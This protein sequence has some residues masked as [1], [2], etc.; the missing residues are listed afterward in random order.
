M[1]QVTEINV[2]PIK[3]CGRIAK[4]TAAVGP[5]GLDGDRRYMLVDENGRFVTQRQH[6]RM[7]LIRVTELEADGYRIEAPGRP[8]LALPRS[9]DSGEEV[10]VTLWRSRVEA[11]LVDDESS[12][13]FAEFLGLPCRLVYMAEHQHRAVPNAAAQFDD[14][15]G[16]ADA[17]PLLLI[18]QASLE[19]LN[20]RLPAPVSM[21]R[22]RPSLVVSAERPF[23]EDS[24]RRLRIGD[25]E[26]EIG[27]SCARC[28]LTTVDPDTGVKDPG[29]EPLKTLRSFRKTDGGVMFGQNVIP[30][31]FGRIRVGDRVEVVT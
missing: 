17:A 4:D 15:V 12:R 9:R 19:D 27:W 13:W 5:R 26:L 1:P 23:A 10:V 31:S 28:V 16:F 24:W 22:F 25:V 29:G 3:S 18:S 7:A 21:R 8:P 2:Y 20:S 30:R 11:T 6:P 14:E